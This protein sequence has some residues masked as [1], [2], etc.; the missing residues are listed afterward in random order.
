MYSHI[1]AQI[2]VKFGTGS[3]FPVPNFTFIRTMC[4][5]LAER[6]PHFWTTEQMQTGMAALRADLP[7]II[8]IG[9]YIIQNHCHSTFAL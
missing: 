6:K 1:S 9:L 7:V 2:N 5:A 3:A 4:V 8:I